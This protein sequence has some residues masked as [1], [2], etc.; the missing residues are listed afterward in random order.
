MS[1]HLQNIARA[2]RQ[3]IIH[4][5]TSFTCSGQSSPVLSPRTRRSITD[6]SARDY[7][8]SQL[9]AQLYGRFY[10]LGGS[11]ASMWGNSGSENESASFTDDLSLANAGTGCVQA[12]WKVIASSDT[13]LVVRRGSGVKLAVRPE[14]CL[15]D[16][17]D[18]VHPG[19]IVQLRIHKELLNVSPGYYMALSNRDD[20]QEDAQ[21]RLRI[22][23]NLKAEGAAHLVRIF[24]GELNKRDL[25]FHLKVLNDPVAYSRCDSGVLY[26]R[27]VDYHAFASVLRQALAQLAPHLRSEVPLFT[28]CLAPGVG[29]AEDP[30]GGES[31]GQHRCRILADGMFHA[32]ERKAR[33]FDDRLAVVV[34]HF[35]SANISLSTPYLNPGSED[36]YSIETAGVA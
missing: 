9:Q 15:V 21:P 28:K 25:F 20:S 1:D 12:G 10:V 26:I 2:I 35:V 3:T 33:R 22:Y 4:S 30:G 23:W 27:R 14:D 29:F 11:D 6:Q 18:T 19:S 31:F 16:A 34:D 8:L 32:W 7:L 24:T 13:E 17:D 5:A 36:N